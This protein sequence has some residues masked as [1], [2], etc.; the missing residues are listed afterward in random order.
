MDYSTVGTGVLGLNLSQNSSQLST[1]VLKLSHKPSKQH[2][3]LT[4]VDFHD[5]VY[6]YA[7]LPFI[8]CVL[9]GFIVMT[10][11][12]L[13]FFSRYARL[14]LRTNILA[15]CPF[16][17]K[18]LRC[19]LCCASNVFFSKLKQVLWP[20]VPNLNDVLENFLKDINDQHWVH[21]I[22]AYYYHNSPSMC[23]HT[24]NNCL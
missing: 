13:S 20:P 19:D 12:L 14:V 1:Q 6:P 16:H 9:F 5:Y 23:T 11:V 18:S 2:K 8:V 15:L 22:L 3:N 4:R 7:G 10:V 17:K 21:H 24:A